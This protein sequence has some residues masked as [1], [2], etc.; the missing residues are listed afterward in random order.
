MFE[1]L[2]PYSILY[3]DAERRTLHI[4]VHF[5]LNLHGKHPKLKKYKVI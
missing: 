4:T 1:A 2:C 5:Y 3:R